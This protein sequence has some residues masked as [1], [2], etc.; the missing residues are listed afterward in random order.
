MDLQYVLWRCCCCL[1][2]VDVCD[3]WLA[4]NSLCPDKDLLSSSVKLCVHR[5]GHPFS[6]IH[7]GR[8]S[9]DQ[10]SRVPTSADLYSEQQTGRHSLHT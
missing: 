5:I 1:Y 8:E 2:V 10:L 3:Y 6:P 4:A 9:V 7:T